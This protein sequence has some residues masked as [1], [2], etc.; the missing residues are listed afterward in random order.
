VN[1]DA[2]AADAALDLLVIQ[3]PGAT[4]DRIAEEMERTLGIPTEHFVEFLK[5]YKSFKRREEVYPIH[6]YLLEAA[7]LFP[8]FLM[9]G[10]AGVVWSIWIW[11]GCGS[12]VPPGS[13]HPKG[14]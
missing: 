13:G 2:P 5:G 6:P 7:K 8:H 12:C 1:F 3:T 9:M 4:L 14:V 11:T 10:L